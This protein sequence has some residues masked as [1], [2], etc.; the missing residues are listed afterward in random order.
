MTIRHLKDYNVHINHT[1]DKTLFICRCQ[2]RTAE[3]Q[4]RGRM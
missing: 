3:W 4:I 1:S 2:D